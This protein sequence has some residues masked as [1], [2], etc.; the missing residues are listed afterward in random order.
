MTASSSLDPLVLTL[1]A[2]GAGQAVLCAL[3]LLAA[4]DRDAAR[5][6]LA[7]V[8]AGL[9]VLAAGPGI[10]QAA[11]AAWPYWMGLVLLALYALPEAFHRYA[12]ALTRS[13]EGVVS[14]GAWSVAGPAAG[15]V[16]A[17]SIWTLPPE[18]LR[19]MFLSGEGPDGGRA[20]LTAILLFILVIAWSAVS[21]GYAWTILRRLRRYRRSLRDVFSSTE[22]RELHWLSAIV[23]AVAAVWALGVAILLWDNL[24]ATLVLPPWLGAAMAL[25]LTGALALRG[26]SQQ[27]GFDDETAQ[28]PAPDKYRK[29]ALEADHARRIAERLDAAMRSDRLYLDPGL[30]L[31]KLARHVATPPNLVSQTLNQTLEETFFDYVNRWRIEAALPRIAEGRETVLAIAL[32][33]GFNTRSTFYTA[34]KTATGMT[35]RAWR[36]AAADAV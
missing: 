24:V 6:W 9:A 7:L 30:S 14:S 34:F 29:S 20:M 25:V 18:A 28:E 21:A 11:P 36:E 15:L 12:A 10:A 26:L 23:L 13:P 19:A 8:F 5:T 27:P 32:D 4:P 31:Q 35:P 16:G 22:R 1:S 17:L 2:A 3:V 33:V